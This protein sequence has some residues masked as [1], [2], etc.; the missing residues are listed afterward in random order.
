MSLLESR[1]WRLPCVL[2]RFRCATGH[3]IRS[4]VTCQEIPNEGLWLD[5]AQTPEAGWP[6]NCKELHRTGKVNGVSGGA[7]V[8]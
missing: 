4:A 6:E 7:P 1:G 8:R 3:R 2:Q 5:A